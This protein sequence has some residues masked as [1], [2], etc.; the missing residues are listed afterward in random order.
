MT[1]ESIK[2]G[3][4][5]FTLPVIIEVPGISD[6]PLVPEDISAGGF[7]FIVDIRP[8]E[9]KEF[10]CTVMI[11]DHEFEG[12]QALVKWVR[13]NSSDPGTWLIGLAFQMS[14]EEREHFETLLAKLLEEIS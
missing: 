13:E 7:S 3:F 12:A 8:E 9:N 1:E 4:E 10:D 5:R 14:G 6:V 2:R 11:L